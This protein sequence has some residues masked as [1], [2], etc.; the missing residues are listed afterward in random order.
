MLAPPWIPVP[1]PGY[2]GIE[3]MIDLL[4]DGLVARGHDVTLL[5]G[6]A[7]RFAWVGAGR[8]SA[9]DHEA[10]ARMH[11]TEKRTT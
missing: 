7:F 3:A 8:T 5:A 9:L 6:L 4:C 11:R 1:P 2:G 10:G